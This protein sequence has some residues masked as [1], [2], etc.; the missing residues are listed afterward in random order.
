MKNE[1]IAYE[2]DMQND[3]MNKNN[4]RLYVPNA[5]TIKA[6]VAKT[7]EYVLDANLRRIRSRDRHFAD[8][9]ELTKNGGPFPEHAMDKIYGQKNQNGQFGIDFIPE[10]KVVDTYVVEN[11]IGEQNKFRTYTNQELEKIAKGNRN[12]KGDI[13]FEKQHYDVFTNPAA[14]KV[15]ELM[16][17]KKAVVYGVATDYCVKAAVIGMQQRGIVTYVVE[18]AIEGITKDGIKLAKQE[19]AANGARFVKLNQLEELLR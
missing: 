8:D 13:V 11:K 1:L 4:G 19:M 16:G 6:N 12:G 14:E 3:F 5:E 7:V 18:D 17:V 10:L 2:V 9:V 15:L